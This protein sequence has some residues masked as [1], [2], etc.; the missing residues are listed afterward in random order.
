[1]LDLGCYCGDQ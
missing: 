1:M